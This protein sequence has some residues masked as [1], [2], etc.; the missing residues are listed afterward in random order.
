MLL[1][2]KGF[3]HKLLCVVSVKIEC[4]IYKED[5]LLLKCIMPMFQENRIEEVSDEE[6]KIFT[7]ELFS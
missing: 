1:K 4:D 5:D 2:I 3:H 7:L 6:E